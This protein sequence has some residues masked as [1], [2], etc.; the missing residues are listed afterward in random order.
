MADRQ[1]EAVDT[2]PGDAAAGVG[3]SGAFRS[4]GSRRECF[5]GKREGRMT[6]MRRI[7][8]GAPQRL[9]MVMMV[10]LTSVPMALVGAGSALA[11]DAIPAAPSSLTGQG[12]RS[13][14]T[15]HW[16]DN[17]TNET[18]FEISRARL[19]GAVWSEFTYSSVAANVTDFHDN[20]VNNAQ[21]AYQVRAVGS[22][23]VSSWTDPLVIEVSL[24]LASPAAP[25]SLALTLVGADV[26]LSWTD[27]SSDESS[28]DIERARYVAGTWSEWAGFPV[29]RNVTTAVD[30]ALPDG[31]YAYLVRSRNPLGQSS[32]VVATITVSTTATAPVAPTGLVANVTGS[33]V[34]LS[35]VD[36]SNNELGFDVMRTR[37]AAG[38][39]T[40]WTGFVADINAQSLTD[41]NVADGLYAYLVRAHN[42]VGVSDW[43]IVVVDVSTSTAPP[44]APS[45]LSVSSVGGSV[46]LHWT[47]NSVSETGFDVERARYVAGVWTEWSGFPADRNATAATDSGVADGQYAYLVR[48]RNSAGSSDWAIQVVI[49]SAST[50]PPP[51]PGGLT[52]DTT[53]STVAL[54][55]L[56]Q[57]GGATGELWFD[58]Q[59]AQLVNGSYTNWTAFTVDK[60]TTSF[61][62]TGVADGTY[63]YLVRAHNPLGDSG[64][65][66]VVVAV[67]PKVT[68][69]IAPPQTVRSW[70]EASISPVGSSLACGANYGWLC[71]AQYASGTTVTMTVTE[72]LG[73]Q[74]AVGF[75]CYRRG[76]PGFSTNAGNPG[77]VP[78]FSLAPSTASFTLTT[79]T[80]CFVS[81]TD[82]VFVAATPPPPPTGGYAYGEWRF[83]LS[84]LPPGDEYCGVLEDRCQGYY[85]AGTP[86]EVSLAAW[87]SNFEPAGFVCTRNSDG[88][89]YAFIPTPFGG[90]IPNVSINCVLQGVFT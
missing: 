9:A 85:D 81:L 1:G 55:W 66:T 26:H 58:V 61:S 69:R 60:N 4:S 57:S 49:V 7:R 56:D 52:A 46:S 62:D 20:S 39:W 89:Y 23:G 24:A 33:S 19:V 68:L 35:W 73:T 43:A 64:W 80:A 65:Q 31:Q 74:K 15:L 82:L 11:A 36:N 5:V 88:S 12:L 21:Y 87:P 29:D 38:A 22:A 63:A 71:Q 47:D 10:L 70:Y 44:E 18:G 45:G 34:S 59:R 13:D 2:R 37:N 41:A 30:P 32:W 67:G 79:D 75:D 25:S 50:L 16:T 90:V 78:D 27:N 54:H 76:T 14:V 53:G 28:F 77:L 40:E 3:S 8:F 48:S 42:A 51:A 72:Y 83:G 84:P 6:M 86:V 17:S